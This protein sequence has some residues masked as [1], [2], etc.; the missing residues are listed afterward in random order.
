MLC[1]RE[2]EREND[3]HVCVSVQYYIKQFILLTL[4]GL[5]L[6][7]QNMFS[8]SILLFVYIRPTPRRILTEPSLKTSKLIYNTLKLH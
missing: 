1:H 6:R 7:T 4:D 2:R 8:N 3:T 5:S